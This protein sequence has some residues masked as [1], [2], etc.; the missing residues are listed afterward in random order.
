MSLLIDSRRRRSG[1]KK[2]FIT[3]TLGVMTFTVTFASSVFST[4]I[5]PTAVLFGVSEELG[6]SLF[7]LGFAFGPMVWGPFSELI[8]RKYSLF[9]PFFIFAIFQVPVA[10]AQNIETVMLFRFLGVTAYSTSYM[11]AGLLTFD[12]G[13]SLQACLLSWEEHSQTFSAP[14]IVE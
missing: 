7:V 2:W 8:G 5:E 14:S 12:R 9:I 3:I 1:L 11:S 10:V 6:V 13:S 4:A